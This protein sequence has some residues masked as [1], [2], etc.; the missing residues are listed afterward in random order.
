VFSDDGAVLKSR[1][2]RGLLRL[3]GQLG[4]SGRRQLAITTYCVYRFFDAQLKGTGR[5]R[6]EISSAAFPEIQ[7]WSARPK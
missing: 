4:I 3:F 1:V 2:V 7:V 5:T 6:P